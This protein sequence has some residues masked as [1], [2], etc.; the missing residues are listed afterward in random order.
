[1]MCFFAFVFFLLGAIAALYSPFFLFLLLF[2]CGCLCWK[3]R[4]KEILPYLLFSLL[5]FLLLFFF[6]KGKDVKEAFGLIVRRKDSYYL[7]LSFKG[8]FYIKSKD[9]SLTLFSIVRVK[10]YSKDLAFSHY[11]SGFSFENYLH[12]QGVFSEFVPSKTEKNFLNPINASFFKNYAFSFCDEKTKTLLS[13]LLFADS[14]YD[15]EENKALS[16]LGLS[17]LLSLSGFHLS[18]FFRVM[19][20]LL[21]EKREK[22]SNILEGVFL[23]FFLFLSGF[24]YSIRRIFLLYALSILQRKKIIDLSRLDRVSVVA[25][26]FLFFEPYSL[27]SAAFY[28]P[29]PLL[30]L[31]A[32]FPQ[33]RDSTWKGRITFFL[34]ISLFYFPYRLY[35]NNGFSFLSPIFQGILVPYSH[36]LFLFS[37]LLLVIPPLGFVLN[38]LVQGFLSI[39]TFFS[40]NSYPLTS[41]KPPIL[42][43]I[44][45]Y[46]VLF[47]LFLFLRYSFPNPIKK[48]SL[49]LV[50]SSL[51]LFVPDVLPH[52]EITFIDV[53]QG[54]ATLVRYQRS[55]ILID[56]GG[57]KNVDLAV[58]CLIP[59]FESRKITSLDA[60][61]LT[62]DDFDHCGARESLEKNFSVKNVYWQTDFLKQKNQII[63]INGLEIQNLNTYV[64]DSSE[65][66]DKS[67]VYAF[68][69]HKKKILIMGDA[70]KAVEKKILISHPNEKADILKVGH[71]GS[72]TS[73]SEEF[74]RAVEPEVAIISC[75]T[76]NS[77]GHPH[78]ETLNTLNKYNVKIRRTDKEGSIIIRL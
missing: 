46:I 25:L 14:L 69:I 50:T 59:Y 64:N 36:L 1:M 2:P 54:D 6:P 45:Y 24:R 51:L 8:T 72:N 23:V 21:G 40:Q 65:D 56:T 19:K 17:S 9:A 76:N 48:A 34:F 58:E 52:Q 29:F 60:V 74:I 47:L 68:T 77:Y 66:N 4:E 75:G 78:K 30:F 37:L 13:S 62:H 32:F 7:L 35:Q 31:L 38:Y 67:G 61:I 43:L 18:F 33:K 55:N 57:K 26:I 15:L 5:A 71:H 39:A 53:D 12:S 73:T 42:F 27:I 22:L 49:V 20:R 16:S 70:P 11:E 3:K 41:G 63:N 44:L 10:G 28:T